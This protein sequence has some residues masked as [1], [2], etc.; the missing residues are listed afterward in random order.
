MLGILSSKPAILKKQGKTF[1]KNPTAFLGKLTGRNMGGTTAL[2]SLEHA[3]GEHYFIGKNYCK[4]IIEEM[5]RQNLIEVDWNH[6][7]FTVLK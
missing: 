1:W 7:T 6:R 3:L 5:A 4:P 2:I